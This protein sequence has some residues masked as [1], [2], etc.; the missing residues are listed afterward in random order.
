MPKVTPLLLRAKLLNSPQFL[1]EN[2]QFLEKIYKETVVD[3]KESHDF[4]PCKKQLTDL[5]DF[6]INDCQLLFLDAY[7]KNIEKLKE[8]K[9]ASNKVDKNITVTLGAAKKLLEEHALRIF[10]NYSKVSAQVFKK[11]TLD[12]CY[13]GAY[14]NLVQALKYFYVDDLVS[15][16][17]Q[18][19]QLLIDQAIASFIEEK[20]LL[21][22]DGMEIAGNEIHIANALFNY[23]CDQY[24]LAS[25]PDFLAST[26]ALEVLDTFKKVLAERFTG[27]N[28]LQALISCLPY[29]PTERICSQDDPETYKKEMANLYN[30]IDFLEDENLSKVLLSNLYHQEED[31]S[32]H[33]YEA[34]PVQNFDKLY[35]AILAQFLF[36]KGYL[37][38]VEF[39]VKNMLVIDAGVTL[40]N[41]RENN[42]HIIDED[43]DTLDQGLQSSKFPKTFISSVL[44]T[45]ST[46]KIYEII[47]S[48]KFN[49]EKQAHALEKLLTRDLSAEIIEDFLRKYS[50]TNKQVISSEFCKK[51]VQH[52]LKKNDQSLTI[53]QR[54]DLFFK[55]PNA[56]QNEIF[57]YFIK[58]NHAEILE[59]ILTYSKQGKDPNF[60]LEI[61]GP[62]KISP[63]LYAIKMSQITVVQILLAHGAK[64]NESVPNYPPPLAFALTLKTFDIFSLLFKYNA[65]PDM[66]WRGKNGERNFLL[67]KAVQLQAFDF[68]EFLL[69]VGANPN[70]GQ[71]HYMGMM[72]EP[73][74]LYQFIGTPFLLA[75]KNNDLAMSLLL[76][77]Y[78]ANLDNEWDG[79]FAWLDG[80]F[81][82]IKQQANTDIRAH[83]AFLLR[84]AYKKTLLKEDAQTVVHLK[85]RDLAYILNNDVTKNFYYPPKMSLKSTRFN[86]T[87][88]S[89]PLPTYS[90]KNFYVLLE[91]NH[92][93][94]QHRQ[95]SFLSHCSTSTVWNL[96]KS[97]QFS[98]VEESLRE[99]VV[100]IL[101]HRPLSFFQLIVIAFKER[102]V[103]FIN[104]AFN[105]LATETDLEVLKSIKEEG[106]DLHYSLKK[107]VL[108]L[109]ILAI[110]GNLETIQWLLKNEDMEGEITLTPHLLEGL[111]DWGLK[112]NKSFDQNINQRYSLLALTEMIAR[113]HQHKAVEQALSDYQKKHKEPPLEHYHRLAASIF[114]PQMLQAKNEGETEKTLNLSLS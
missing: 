104:D 107:D 110:K 18:A 106:V 84:L 8:E 70:I 34:K 52:L 114:I 105:V 108:F 60:L 62:D 69:A 10:Q 16:I 3:Y 49:A 2:Y 7:R 95:Y 87:I 22:V 64:P 79:T 29:P 39:V 9:S 28:F 102:V 27:E 35:I 37:N 36:Q 46:K 40:C 48:P 42:F 43:N 6:F 82:P 53:D 44:N 98:M 81:G 78:H 4:V 21:L 57:F 86:A 65:N 17:V 23:V 33:Y 55:I 31:Y 50:N 91:Q 75:L 41:C 89:L 93:H 109:Y 103:S 88:A 11:F 19:K 80:W 74:N 90:E 15:F 13:S 25:I 71:Y 20:Q 94:S 66:N 51:I 112:D 76:K 47:Q 97:P 99:E 67:S 73:V 1:E 32:L 58:N 96:Y 24:A 38:D 113:V 5:L 45:F 14:A 54:C 111:R 56:S 26:L 68:V 30:F 83:A 12:H 61:T 77:K 100:S 101:L 63:L 85:A 72:L 59:K 92:L